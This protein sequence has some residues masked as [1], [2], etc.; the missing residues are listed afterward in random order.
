MGL[1]WYYCLVK[2]VNSI[3]VGNVFLSTNVRLKKKTQP[4]PPPLKTANKTKQE[5]PAK[6]LKGNAAY[7]GT[8]SLQKY[9]VVLQDLKK[10]PD[11]TNQE[12]ET[13]LQ[14]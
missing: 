8:L 14:K 2:K 12:K 3:L 7:L 6:K 13:K 9:K 1:K 5:I 11:I 4:Q 10:P